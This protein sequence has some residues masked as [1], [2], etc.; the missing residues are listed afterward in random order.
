[1][2][3]S[4][5]QEN[6]YNR[7]AETFRMKNIIVAVGSTRKPKLNAV[8]E[9]LQT[10]KPFFPVGVDFQIL[11]REVA[12]GV[13]PT[14][15]S[16]AELMLGA[17]KRTQAL[18][19]LAAES[20]EKWDYLVG[21]EGGL[22]VIMEDRARR[23]F[24][25]SWAY[26]TNGTTGHYGRSG[27]LEIPEVLAAEVLEKGIELSE[28]I[29]RFAGEKGVRNLQGAWGVLTLNLIDRQSAFR[30]G[31]LAAFAPFYNAGMYSSASAANG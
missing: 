28:A 20:S 3:L 13:S 2:Q 19:H 26:V 6:E 17:R 14:P 16:R 1:M 15:S 27:S 12:S 25:E 30:V 31:V 22:D 11:G 24:L 21:L 29:D 5:K 9:A 7:V 4:F 10:I 23:V 8:S 18:S